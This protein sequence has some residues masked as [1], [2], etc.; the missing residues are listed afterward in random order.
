MTLFD[1]RVRGYVYDMILRAGEVPG[2][3]EVAREVSAS[4]EDVRAAFQRLAAARALV[5]HPDTAGIVMAPPFSA[6]P[7][8]FR[9]TIPPRAY[10]A[11]CI[12]DALG[13]AAMLKKDARIETSCGDCGR[14][15]T[16]EVREAAPQGDGVMHFAV[17]AR[18][19]WNDIVFT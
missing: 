13:V 19:W 6:V 14:P 15:E 18:Q 11:N 1:S 17:P 12:W 5:V 3:S 4:T 10:Y 9:V 7:T 8:P 2:I 16:L